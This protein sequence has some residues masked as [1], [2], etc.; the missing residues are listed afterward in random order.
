M[1]VMASWD[2]SRYGDAHLIT[3]RLKDGAEACVHPT[4]DAAWFD[5]KRERT[6]R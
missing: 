6:S 4:T 1:R 3:E 2:K 5:A